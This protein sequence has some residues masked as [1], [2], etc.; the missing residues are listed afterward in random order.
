MPSAALRP[1]PRVNTGPVTRL[2]S[3]LSLAALRGDAELCVYTSSLQSYR[4]D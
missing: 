3:V 2:L 1:S 4:E